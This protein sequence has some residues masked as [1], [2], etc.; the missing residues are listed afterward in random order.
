MNR[1]LRR[2]PLELSFGA[3][4][5]IAI[6]TSIPGSLRQFDQ[7]QLVSSEIQRNAIEQQ[8]LE[9][10]QEA[11]A[12]KAKIA[13]ERYQTGCLL[14]QLRN[15]NTLISLAQ[16]MPVVDSRTGNA[17]PPGTVVC[18]YSGNTAVM[19]AVDGKSLAHDLAFTGNR[20]IVRKAIER[21]GIEL[22]PGT[23]EYGTGTRTN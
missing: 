8:R 22:I 16:G 23:K 2:Y 17:I 1:I 11:L 12:E 15:N 3:I 9:A 5:L 18:D 21:S 6:A 4:A 14:I 20:T 7:M 19:T 13:E 10:Q